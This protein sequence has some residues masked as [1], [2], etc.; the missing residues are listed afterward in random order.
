ML[1]A[2]NI[3]TELTGGINIAFKKYENGVWFRFDFVYEVMT[4]QENRVWIDERR[5]YP[6]M[7]HQTLPF[8]YGYKEELIDYADTIVYCAICI[9]TVAR[10]GNTKRLFRFPL[11]ILQFSC[12]DGR[13][14]VTYPKSKSTA[15]MQ[16][17]ITDHH[18]AE[19]LVA[20]VAARREMCAAAKVDATKRRRTQWT[21]ARLDTWTLAF[22]S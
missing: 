1:A 21:S 9:Q 13:P 18:R 7:Q 15:C 11:H 2:R 5:P 19:L 22:V 8:F 12:A 6:G 14:A 17:H 20:C 10:E 3:S 4:A 16:R